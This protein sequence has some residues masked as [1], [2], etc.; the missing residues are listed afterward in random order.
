MRISDWSSDVCS[1]DLAA[2]R[3]VARFQ[4][5]QRRSARIAQMMKRLIRLVLPMR[6][7]PIAARSSA[8]VVLLLIVAH[9]AATRGRVMPRA[10]PNFYIGRTSVWGR[11]LQE[12]YVQGVPLTLKKKNQ[13]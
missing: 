13:N 5:D 3:W 12:G 1:S 10:L 11:W 9:F 2:P 4:A 8:M 6:R 7:N